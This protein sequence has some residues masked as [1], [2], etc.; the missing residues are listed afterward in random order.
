MRKAPPWVQQR[1]AMSWNRPAL[2]AQTPAWKVGGGFFSVP[3]A[4]DALFGLN[5][6]YFF[7]GQRQLL[8]L[9]RDDPRPEIPVWPRRDIALVDFLL[10]YR[11]V[12]KQHR[13]KDHH[14]RNQYRCA[15]Q[16]PLQ[17]LVHLI[18]P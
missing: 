6:G 11:L 14:Q 13:H 8:R 9:G 1:L 4:R 7:G 5:P 3:L 15:D 18:D 10:E 16:A 12:L 2:S 17:T